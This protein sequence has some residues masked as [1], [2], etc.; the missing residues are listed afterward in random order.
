MKNILSIMFLF[1]L[2]ASSCS[3]DEIVKKQSTSSISKLYTA[4]LSPTIAVIVALPAFKPIITPF[5]ATAIV[6]ES[7]E[8]Q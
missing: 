5:D 4:S 6:V 1:A 3:E 7:D 2:L 8:D